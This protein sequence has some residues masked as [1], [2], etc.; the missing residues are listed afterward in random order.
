MQVDLTNEEREELVRIL[1]HYLA[2]T[3]VEV[4]RART[5]A[6]RDQLHDE[7]SLLRGLL[8]KLGTAGQ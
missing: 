5:S 3:K 8:E 7:E 1:D 4:R 2:D 6:F